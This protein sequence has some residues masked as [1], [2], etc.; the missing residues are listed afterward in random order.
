MHVGGAYKG[1]LVKV[2]VVRHKLARV[3]ACSVS[4]LRAVTNHVE[5]RLYSYFLSFSVFP[6]QLTVL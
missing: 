4:A 5:K 6:H 2:G 1:P 3:S